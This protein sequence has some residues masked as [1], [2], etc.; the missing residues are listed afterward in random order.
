MNWYIEALKKYADFNGRA[1]RA[2]YWMFTLISLIIYLFLY[3]IDKKIMPGS[4]VQVI[5]SVYYLAVLLPSLAVN[6]R[7]LHDIGRSGWWSLIAV[8]PII[9]PIVY[10]IWLIR[11]G[12][13][14]ANKWGPNPKMATA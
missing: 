8:I 10:L 6:V 2:E 3:L 11:E 13:P 7:R 9:G 12:Q 4:N 5:S 14:A 1:S